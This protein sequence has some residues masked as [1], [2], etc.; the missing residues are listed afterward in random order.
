MQFGPIRDVEWL[1]WIM[2]DMPECLKNRCLMALTLTNKGIPVPCR[3]RYQ[4]SP[5]S[6]H[7]L[8]EVGSAEGLASSRLFLTDTLTCKSVM[9]IAKD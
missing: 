8:L 7:K 9:G 6:S 5:I 1:A 4:H 3:G 2:R